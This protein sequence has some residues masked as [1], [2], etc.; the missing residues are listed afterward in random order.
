MFY[1]LPKVVAALNEPVSIASLFVLAL[2]LAALIRRRFKVCSTLP[3]GPPVDNLIFG[4]S[5]PSCECVLLALTSILHLFSVS[6]SAFRKF[7][8]WATEYGPVF[9]LR[10]GFT[11]I[12]VITRYRAAVEIMERRG[13]YLADRPVSI[14]AGETVSGGNRLLLIPVGERFKRMR[15][16]C[17]HRSTAGPL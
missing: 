1:S 2:T 4:H 6:S 15:R 7:D 9:S 8:E 17:F 14:A 5:I 12:I 13:A 11:T 3:P 16:S 10:Q